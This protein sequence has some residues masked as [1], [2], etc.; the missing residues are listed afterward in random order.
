MGGVEKEG[1]KVTGEGLGEGR[2]GRDVLL[3]SPLP[4]DHSYLPYISEGVV[5]KEEFKDMAIAN[6]RG[7]YYL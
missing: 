3:R 1:R 2:T 6:I 4:K 5:S 7:S